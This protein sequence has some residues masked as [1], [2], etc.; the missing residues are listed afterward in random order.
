MVNGD[1]EPG[2]SR[3][4]RRRW[5]FSL[6]TL[7]IA[8]AVVSFLGSGYAV[9]QS[10][11]ESRKALVQHVRLINAALSVEAFRNGNGRLPSEEEGIGVLVTPS[12]ER[13][14]ARPYLDP[15]YAFDIWG[16]DIQYRVIGPGDADYDL[17]SLGR[18]GVNEAGL[19]D[20]ISL[21]Q[22]Y[23]RE[24]YEDYVV[25]CWNVVVTLFFIIVFVLIFYAF[26]E[27]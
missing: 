2:A 7:L 9:W 5:Q 4:G 16:N 22:G 17:L 13:D 25:I 18:D 3:C 15:D 27:F 10:R 19:G 24:A 20:D 8:V 11:I 12:S 26:R 21:R 1:S 23:A 14:D 6:L